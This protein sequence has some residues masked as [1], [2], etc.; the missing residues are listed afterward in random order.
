MFELTEAGRFASK[1]GEIRPIISKNLTLYMVEETG[2]FLPINTRFKTSEK[3]STINWRK[4]KP[5]SDEEVT[6]WFTAEKGTELK[7]DDTIEGFSELKTIK[8][9][10]LVRNKLFGN[11]PKLKSTKQQRFQGFG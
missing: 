10:D 7:V 8:R 1:D 2:E 5:P 9:D 11:L 4:A 3:W 6:K